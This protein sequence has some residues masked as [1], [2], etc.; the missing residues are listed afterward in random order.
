MN[1]HRTTLHHWLSFIGK[2]RCERIQL[3]KTGYMTVSEVGRTAIGTSSS[4]CPDRVTHATSGAKSS[5]WSF[6]ASS[7]AE[8]TKRGK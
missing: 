8:D 4:D 1:S 2:S 6:S 3:A 5:M 7:L